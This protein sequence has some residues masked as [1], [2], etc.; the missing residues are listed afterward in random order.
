MCKGMVGISFVTFCI[1]MEQ[2][3]KT[4]TVTGA[5]AWS[6]NTIQFRF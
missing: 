3:L 4:G 2:F 6:K 1:K 5:G